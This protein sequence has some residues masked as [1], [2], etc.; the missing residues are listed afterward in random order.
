MKVLVYWLARTAVFFAVL[1][2]LWLIGWWDLIAVVASF[3]VAWLLSYVLFPGMRDSAAVQMNEW[4]TSLQRQNRADDADED[5]E[6]TGP[7][8]RD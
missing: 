2:A 6:A 8:S 4:A 3:I 5:A 1:G 7:G